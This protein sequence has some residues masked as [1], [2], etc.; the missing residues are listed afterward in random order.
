M[1]AAHC[2]NNEDVTI[3]IT[4]PMLPILKP[5]TW[6]LI[7]RKNIR[8]AES[9]TVSLNVIKLRNQYSGY[10]HTV[11][12]MLLIVIG[13]NDNP[14]QPIRVAARPHADPDDDLL[15]NV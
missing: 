8:S 5:E 12:T 6:L 13:E 9:S 10:F 15:K 3:K 1:I 4:K 11:A 7:V 14:D 2:A